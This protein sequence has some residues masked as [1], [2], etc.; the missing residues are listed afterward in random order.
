MG[1]Q[2]K[3]HSHYTVKQ[4]VVDGKHYGYL[5]ERTERMIRPLT[6]EELADYR[7]NPKDATKGLMKLLLPED[8]AI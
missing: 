2:S 7:N 5:V 6:S 1:H 4:N 3:V 8:D